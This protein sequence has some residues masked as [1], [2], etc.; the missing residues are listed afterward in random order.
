M[1]LRHRGIIV[2]LC[3]L[4]LACS[5]ELDD[6]ALMRDP[7]AAAE[8]SRIRKL[9]VANAQPTPDDFQSLLLLR[10]R[11]PQA[12]LIA[13]TYEQFLYSRA[14]W[15]ALIAQLESLPL[16][17]LSSRQAGWLAEAH[18]RLGN[19]RE[20]VELTPSLRTRF[21]G[22]RSFIKL[23]AAALLGLDRAEEADAQLDRHWQ[24]FVSEGDVDAIVLRARILQRMGNLPE[25]ISTFELALRIAPQTETAL[26]ALARIYYAQGDSHRAQALMAQVKRSKALAS[27]STTQRAQLVSLLAKVEEAWK[28]KNYP[29][30]IERATTALAQVQGQQRRVLLEFIAQS[31]LQLG[32]RD[33]AARVMAQIEQGQ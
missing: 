6:T 22:E 10:E 20:L 29:L 5:P 12:A 4:L 27:A 19:Y 21:A 18:F 24:T 33:A 13:D 15:G 16:D 26:L 1:T 8:V 9:L 11:Y 17:R 28:Q 32:D 2:A 7:Q 25:A 23:E 31:H 30:V 3:G 14:D